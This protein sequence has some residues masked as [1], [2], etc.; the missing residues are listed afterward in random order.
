MYKMTEFSVIQN[1]STTC[2]YI[3]KQDSNNEE[4]P[5][6]QTIKNNNRPPLLH[7]FIPQPIFLPLTSFKERVVTQATM[8]SC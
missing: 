8:G 1:I 5:G 3:L 7:L 2:Q 4:K 6:N